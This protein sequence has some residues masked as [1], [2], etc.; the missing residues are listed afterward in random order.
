MNYQDYWNEARQA[1]LALR[2]DILRDV[3]DYN[4]KL[5]D[6]IEEHV[7][8]MADNLCIWTSDVRDLVRA[9]EDADVVDDYSELVFP[10]ASRDEQNVSI[11]YEF[12]SVHIWQEVRDL[13]E[14]REGETA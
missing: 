7:R 5:D 10:E 3:L 8:Q 2:S 4:K 6:S 14:I 13:F 11:A 9:L 1:A 12:W